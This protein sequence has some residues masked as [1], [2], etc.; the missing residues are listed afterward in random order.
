MAGT[1]GEAHRWAQMHEE[2]LLNIARHH[3]DIESLLQTFFGFL[4][5]RTD[6]FHVIETSGGSSASGAATVG[7]PEGRAEAMVGRAFKQAQLN[8]R[9]RAQP[10]LLG[11]ASAPFTL[12]PQRTEASASS[13]QARAT[14]SCAERGSEATGAPAAA[15]LGPGGGP[16]AAGGPR[17]AQTKDAR[18]RE[19]EEH[20]PGSKEE[21][22]APTSRPSGQKEA[23]GESSS[24]PAQGGRGKELTTWNGGVY[25]NYRWTQSLSDLTVQ[26]PLDKTKYRSK[27]DLNIAMTPTKLKVTLAGEVLLDGEWEEPVNALESL[28]QVEDGPYLLLS[29]EKARENWWASVLKGEEKID[30]TK[31]TPVTRCVAVQI[32]SVKR[33]EDFDAATQAH[34]RK[35]MF[36]QQQRMRGEKTSE[37]IEREELLRKAWDAEGS[38]F[39]GTP[40]D[41]SVLNLQSGLPPDFMSKND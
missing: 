26:V 12:H 15:A 37:E 38:P 40:F 24:S 2:L 35:M 29:I 33:V 1:D 23:A 10:H 13:A 21:N 7:F 6:F 39:S 8:Y 4:E 36:D 34:I 3:P 16:A 28:W 22:A 25:R 32:E 41:P 20:A 30:T 18:E 11:E 31:A 9:R 27:R 17:D 19:A 5:R 14:V